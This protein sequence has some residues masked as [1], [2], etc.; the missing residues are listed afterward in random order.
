MN[1][2][3]A[4]YMSVYFWMGS[5]SSCRNRYGTI[6]RLDNPGGHKFIYL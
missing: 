1:E 5:K 4:S 2:T 6:I 3:L